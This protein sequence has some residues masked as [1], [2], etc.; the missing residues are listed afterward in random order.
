[1]YRADDEVR[2]TDLFLRCDYPELETESYKIDPQE[3][4]IR[5]VGFEGDF[6][7]ISNKFDREIRQ[8][9]SP[10][11]LSQTIPDE[12]QEKLTPIPFGDPVDGFRASVSTGPEIKAFV[13]AYYPDTEILEIIH[14]P[15][16]NYEVDIL[17][18]TGTTD[19]RIREM[20]AFLET[21]LGTDTVR[22][23][24][25][26][27][28]EAAVPADEPKK[29]RAPGE[30]HPL[31][32]LMDNSRLGY[33]RELACS[34]AEADYWFSNAE[35]IYRNRIGRPDLPFFRDRQKNC[36]MDCSVSTGLDIRNVLFLYETVYIGMPMEK[37]LDSFLIR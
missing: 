27:T 32:Q 28:G 23:A 25:K 34:A 16:I 12:Y 18:G 37:H 5:C 22:V 30:I 1:M 20:S 4:V 6:K 21:V 7:G 9:G 36:F 17:V 3:Y 10:V 19:E 2:R 29:E 33:H 13:E 35:D 24:R 26:A 14:H 15:G 31:I 8:M 11:V